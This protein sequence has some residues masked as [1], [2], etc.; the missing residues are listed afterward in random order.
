MK[1]HLLQ[2]VSERPR[3]FCIRT[4]ET[5]VAGV[6][7]ITGKYMHRI[8]TGRLVLLYGEKNNEN[9]KPIKRNS[10][11]SPKNRSMDSYD[12]RARCI[13]LASPNDAALA[14]V[15]IFY[16]SVCLCVMNSN[17]LQ[18]FVNKMGE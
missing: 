3:W 5:V 1:E 14:H 11:N 9:E 4:S 16:Y 10:Y 17:P 2:A 7:K 8:I 13:V 6:I 15:I 18:Q 12:Y